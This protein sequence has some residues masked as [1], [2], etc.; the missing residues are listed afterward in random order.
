MRNDILQENEDNVFFEPVF[1]TRLKVNEAVQL[2]YTSGSN[3]GLKNRKFLTAG[4]SVFTF[5]VV[6]NVGG[7]GFK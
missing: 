2:Q 1:F 6:I 7:L 4:S 3:I 5:G